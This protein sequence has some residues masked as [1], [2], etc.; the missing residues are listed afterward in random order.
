MKRVPSDL[1]ME[2]PGCF[3]PLITCI[4]EAFNLQA[5]TVKLYHG[6]I[7]VRLFFKIP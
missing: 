1:L 6:T 4:P 3:Y 5:G 7:M 2:D